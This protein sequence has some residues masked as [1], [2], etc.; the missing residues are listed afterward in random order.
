MSSNN[1]KTSHTRINHQL[2]LAVL[3]ALPMLALA[4]I[5]ASAACDGSI[6]SPT[7]AA[8]TAISISVRCNGTG[9]TGNL[10]NGVG[11]TLVDSTSVA[12]TSTAP[13]VGSNVLLQFDGQ[14]RTLNNTGDIINNRV[15]TGTTG[16]RA[17]TA[18]LM[19]AATLNAGAGTVF[20]TTGP[21]TNLPVTGVTTVT[22]NA[23]PTAAYVGQTVV[24]GRYNAAEGDFA[25]GVTRIITAVDVTAKTI[26][27]ADALPA[28]FAGT[29]NT[30][31]IG[32]KVVSNYGVTS[33]VGGVAYH[34]VVNNSGTISSQITAAEI[35]GGKTGA[36]G[37]YA[38]VSNT[39]AVKGVTMSV[40]GDYLLN[41][42]KTGVI[43][44]K[45]DGIGA[46]YAIEQGGAVEGLVVNNKGLISAERTSS[47]TLVN[48]VPNANPTA[49]AVIGGNT[50]A[51]QTVALVNAINTQE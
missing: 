33:T 16:T 21:E 51:A 28:N 45:H 48:N 39:A 8:G 38:A 36:A 29:A 50:Y 41:N 17:R 44:V 20:A 31:P 24:F 43:S 10:T 26:T 47:L 15:I 7:T 35:N 9:T 6:A 11:T 19:G 22:L 42:A 34:N 37:A 23:A 12:G 14:G 32:Y 25:A 27:F 2:H 18:V 49:R 40:E 13:V 1:S 3:A 46:A 30:D 4:S 5:N